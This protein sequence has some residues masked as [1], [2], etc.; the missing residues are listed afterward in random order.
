[1]VKPRVAPSSLIRLPEVLRVA[2]RVQRKLKHYFPH[3]QKSTIL[4]KADGA[5]IREFRGEKDTMLPLVTSFGL[6]Y[7]RALEPS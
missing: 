2:F 1:M 3:L 4:I 5:R 7:V 6:E